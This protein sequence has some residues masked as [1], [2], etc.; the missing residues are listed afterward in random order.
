MT[1]TSEQIVKSYGY[2]L[3]T[4]LVA[5][6]TGHILTLHRIPRGRR[7]Q[8]GTERRPVA[9]IHHGL[10]GCSD[11]WLL[12]GPQY[13]LPYILADSGYDVWLFN[14]RG[15]VYSRKHKTLNPDQDAEYWDFGIEEMG[16]YDLPV[17][18]DYILNLTN[19][20]DLFFLGHSIGSS[21]GLISCSLRPEYNEKIRLF[22]AL[23]PLTNVK[24]KLTPFHKV[25]FLL[26][27]ALMVS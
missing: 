15:N 11:M 14:T 12:R 4:H 3:D 19:Q 8:N 1:L 6:E 23:G 9:F 10:F 25:V 17:T 13:D 18:I 27:S 26:G 5:S 20:K 24:H 22:L 16:Y 7:N 2:R 21:A